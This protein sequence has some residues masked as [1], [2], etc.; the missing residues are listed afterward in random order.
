[1]KVS[2]PERLPG[3]WRN[4]PAGTYRRKLTGG[5]LPARLPGATSRNSAVYNGGIYRREHTG[6]NVLAETYWRKHTGGNIL[7]ETYWQKHTG[8]NLPAETYRRNIP[9]ETYQRAFPDVGGIYRREHTGGY[10]LAETYRREF[11]DV[12]AAQ[13]TGASYRQYVNASSRQLQSP[14]PG[15]LYQVST[16]TKAAF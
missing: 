1:L 6:R 13:V 14:F 12:G 15:M 16:A 9:A 7:A 4:I 5:N 8:G 2:L 3:S 10:I 11:P